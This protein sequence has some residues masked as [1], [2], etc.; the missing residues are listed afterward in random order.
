MSGTS[1]HIAFASRRD[2]PEIA[3]VYMIR[4][5]EAVIYIGSSL[6]IRHRIVNHNKL[7]LFVDEG[8]VSIEYL[9]CLPKNLNE[10]E[11]EKIRQHFPKL[12]VLSSRAV[13]KQYANMSP[14]QSSKFKSKLRDK[15]LILLQNR[16][17]TLTINAISDATGLD[18]SWL[19]QFSRGTIKGPDVCRIETLYEYL[20]GA[21][22]NLGD[23]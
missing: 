19:A 10:L 22:L 21:P 7:D 1:Q 20:T 11:N 23:S 8:A 14:A 18:K 5:T 12:N 13:R 16:P 6:N 15:T 17:N 2:L 3:A 4:S 9:E